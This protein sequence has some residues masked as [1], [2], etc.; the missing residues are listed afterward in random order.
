MPETN[1]TNKIN[2][3]KQ[4]L[5]LCYPDLDEKYPKLNKDLSDIKDF[6]NKIAHSMLD[7]SYEF[8][9]KKNTDQIQFKSFKN[10]QTQ[11][12]KVTSDDIKEKLKHC[13]QVVLMLGDIQS[14]V[15]KRNSTSG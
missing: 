13:T 11:S 15:R 4:L 5:K 3:L 2:I 12:H 10:G 8:L 9:A 14:E 6:R 1:F 7:T